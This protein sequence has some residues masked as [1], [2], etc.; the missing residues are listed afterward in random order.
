MHIFLQVNKLCIHYFFRGACIALHLRYTTD[1][2]YSFVPIPTVCMGCQFQSCRKW[3]WTIDTL[4][5][6]LEVH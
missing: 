1:T 6:M 4:I 3:E 5:S 2:S